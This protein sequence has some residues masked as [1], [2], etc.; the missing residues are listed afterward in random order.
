MS[1]PGY[2]QWLMSGDPGQSGETCPHCG[3]EVFEETLNWYWRREVGGTLHG[4]HECPSCGELL[5]IFDHEGP[6]DDW[7]N[8]RPCGCPADTHLADCP[9][10]DRSVPD[11]GHPLYVGM[12]SADYLDLQERLHRDGID[13]DDPAHPLFG[14]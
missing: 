10:N 1:L 5:H 2:D 13:L 11:D 14:D 6:P 3:E 9:I 4:I 12:T 8:P 7:D